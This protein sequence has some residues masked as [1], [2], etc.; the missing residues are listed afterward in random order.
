MIF[1]TAFVECAPRPNFQS[2][3][4]ADA[5]LGSAI[6]KLNAIAKNIPTTHED[7]SSVTTAASFLSVLR[8][9]LNKSNF[10]AVNSSHH[11]K[12]SLNLI[13]KHGQ[14]L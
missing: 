8:L 14:H 4:E 10:K 7:Y 5:A 9:N 13:E 3:E 12:K 11:Y 6:E 1:F 2:Y